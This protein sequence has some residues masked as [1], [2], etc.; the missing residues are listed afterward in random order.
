MQRT[1]YTVGTTQNYITQIAT[2]QCSLGALLSVHH[3]HTVKEDGIAQGSLWK[4]CFMG[5]LR[6]SISLSPLV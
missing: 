4:V 6:L 1:C 2:E 5:R 3:R